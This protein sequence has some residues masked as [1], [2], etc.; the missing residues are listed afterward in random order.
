[1][2]AWVALYTATHR[3]HEHTFSFL[4]FDPAVVS[5][6]RDGGPRPLGMGYTALKRGYLRFLMTFLA[7]R[8]VCRSWEVSSASRQ[9]MP[10]DTLFLQGGT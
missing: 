10:F 8:V 3:R 6:G 4:L 9:M 1:M 7:T 5:R 2:L